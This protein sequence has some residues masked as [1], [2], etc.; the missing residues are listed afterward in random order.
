M[1]RPTDSLRQPALSWYLVG[2]DYI[3]PWTLASH[4]WEVKFVPTHKPVSIF[5][6]SFKNVINRDNI[7]QYSAELLY[8][9]TAISVL[10]HGISYHYSFHTI[11]GNWISYYNCL[12]T[13]KYRNL[14][15]KKKYSF[16]LIEGIIPHISI[17]NIESLFIRW[18]IIS[19]F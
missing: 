13:K 14:L 8:F 15:N 19:P 10:F 16:S 4:R 1:I 17:N 3:T 2:A 18:K 11:I 12:Y 5:R 9:N 6:E 7:V